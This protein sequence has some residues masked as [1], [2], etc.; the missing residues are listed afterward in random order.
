MWGLYLSPMLINLNKQCQLM[1]YLPIGLQLKYIRTRV[2]PGGIKHPLSNSYLSAKNA[3]R[4]ANG[5][6]AQAEFSA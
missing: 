3:A 2:M 1:V 6:L 4:E 5:H